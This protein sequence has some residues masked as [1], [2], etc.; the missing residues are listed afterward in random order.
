MIYMRSVEKCADTIDCC[1]SGPVG[2]G[3]R[4]ENGWRLVAVRGFE[5]HRFRC[6]VT[7]KASG[8]LVVQMLGV[9]FPALPRLVSIAGDAPVL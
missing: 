6:R 8:L 5:S 1:G 3:H 7:Q 4:L 9:R 2:R